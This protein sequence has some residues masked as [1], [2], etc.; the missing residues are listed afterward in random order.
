[1]SYR[2]GKR[3]LSNLEGVHPDLDAVAKLAI[4]KTKQDFTIIEGLRSKKR[5]RELVAQGFSKTMNSRHL[6]GHAIDIVPYPIP[7]DWRKYKNS[8]WREIYEAMKQSAEELGVEMDF[9]Y[10][11][12]W[13]KPHYQLDWTHYP[14]RSK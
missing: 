12:G 4:K 2:L 9:G 11:W 3:S 5:Q 13:D 8:Q 7:R 6:T 10:E 1:M 14:V